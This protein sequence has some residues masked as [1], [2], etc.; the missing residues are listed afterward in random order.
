MGRAT[1]YDIASRA[2]VSVSTVSLAINHP[3]RV[4]DATR[5]RIVQI[6][7]ELGYRPDGAWRA[8]TGGRPVGIAVAAPFTSYRS[9]GLRLTGI[10]DRLRDTGIDV[11]V[12]DLESASRVDA[13]LL[14]AL[15]I[16]AG[17]DGIIVMGVP[18]SEEG[19]LKLADWGPP[20]VLLDARHSATPTVLIDDE[21][22]GRLIGEHL[23]ALGHRHVAFVHEGQRS[24]D[25]VSAGMLRGQGLG[26]TV[27]RLDS[28]V[29]GEDLLSRLPDGVTAIVASHDDLAARVLRLLRTSGR[30]VPGDFSLV[31]FDD[32]ALADAL[33]LT[34]VRQPFEASGR[35]A[36]DLLLGLMDGRSAE[37]ARIQ[38]DVELVVRETTGALA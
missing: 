28:A 15:P 36:A 32:E 2:G 19:G 13:P 1:I 22:G 4:S 37:V 33:G 8:R 21:R 9:F 11:L 30:A 34:T 17:V 27:E 10:L 31:G 5:A 38:L 35:V 6:A 23:T 16:R 25:Y 14:D 20:V 24:F 12:Y 3:H 7:H 18:L 26:D 29:W